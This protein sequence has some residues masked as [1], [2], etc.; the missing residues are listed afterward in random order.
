[1]TQIA[2]PTTAGGGVGWANVGGPSYVSS[3]SDADDATYGRDD[4]TL[5]SGNLNGNFASGLIDP[6][7]NSGFSVKVTARSTA[8][9]VGITMH[10][11]IRSGITIVKTF[12]IG[13]NGNTFTPVDAQVTGSFAVYTLPLSSGEAALFDF[14]AQPFTYDFSPSGIP[15]GLF[16]VSRIELDVPDLNHTVTV[17]SDANSAFDQEGA[18]VVADGG[19]LSVTATPSAGYR[20]QDILVDGVSVG[21]ATGKTSYVVAL[22]NVTAD[23][24]VSVSAYAYA[25]TSMTDR[26]ERV[27]CVYDFSR[28]VENTGLAQVLGDKDRY[29]WSTPLVTNTG[30]MVRTWDGNLYGANDSNT[31]ATSN[32]AIYQLE[33]GL[34]DTPVRVYGLVSALSTIAGSLVQSTG[35]ITAL[36]ATDFRRVAVG[37]KVTGSGIT[38]VATVTAK[39]VTGDTITVTGTLT[40]NTTNQPYTCWGR[41]IEADAFFLTDRFGE[42]GGIFSG[43]MANVH[44]ACP[45][46]AVFILSHSFDYA[47]ATLTELSALDVTGA[48]NS[49]THRAP[50]FQ[51]LVEL[52]SA[53]RTS[54]PV[55]EFKISF[56]NGSAG[57]DTL[58]RAECWGIEGVFRE[59]EQ[60]K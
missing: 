40:G 6:V 33:T 55:Q 37:A 32:G 58:A 16:D 60:Y 23:H 36:L 44:Y 14:S 42:V 56:R 12:V 10:L 3:I 51:E 11:I 38:G 54:G 26:G 2:L 1:M 59:L 50:P 39:S 20:I 41:E 31:G 30:A 4:P 45:T 17:S 28:T 24:T 21:D 15:A 48:A 5:G 22:T 25:N 18:I 8:V 35:V 13:F 7:T 9:G 49:V 19:N 43:Q 47:R 29:P 53:S 52:P 57:T 34:L 46:G 27:T